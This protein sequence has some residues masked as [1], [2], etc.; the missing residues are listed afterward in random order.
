MAAAKRKREDKNGPLTQ[1]ILEKPSRVKASD[2]ELLSV[3]PSLNSNQKGTGG[4]IR[5]KITS[6]NTEKRQHRGCESVPR[7]VTFLKGF[8]QQH[9]EQNASEGNEIKTIDELIAEWKEKEKRKEATLSDEQRSKRRM[10]LKEC[11]QQ[12]LERIRLERRTPQHDVEMMLGE[13]PAYTA[14]TIGQN[15]RQSLA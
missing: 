7:V 6:S 3:Q 8:N 15:T 12:L 5:E 11:H 10:G 1:P 4:N 13:K 14:E 9:R 2:H